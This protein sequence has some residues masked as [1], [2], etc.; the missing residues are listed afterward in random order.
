MG[1]LLRLQHHSPRFELPPSF[2]VE[3]SK[4]L[5]EWR[6]SL[7]WKVFKQY[8]ETSKNAFNPPQLVPRPVEPLHGAI[9]HL[10]T[11]YITCPA[12][13]R[14]YGSP[15]A[16]DGKYLCGIETLR[17]PCSIFSLGSH[18]QTTFEEEMLKLTPC[19][20]YTFDCYAGTKKLGPNH[21]YFQLCIGSVDD[22]NNSY[23]TYETAVMMTG[24]LT[25]SLLKMDIEGSEFDILPFW[26]RTYK[27]LPEQLAI[28]IHNAGLYLMTPH[29][30]NLNAE[31]SGHL[32]WA[33]IEEIN[34]G[35]LALTFLHLAE[36]GYGIVMQD[37]KG[38]C[39]EY[40][41]MRV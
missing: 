26:D 9:H 11:P 37:V 6:S 30:H 4:N 16:D 19:K 2:Y 12:S 29:L 39:A 17:A 8:S 18:G 28:E 41:L 5:S 36:L 25:P 20:V 7:V 3:G 15:G 31:A 1:C 24:G 34:L 32:I 21:E 14:F 22:K 33:G 40:V 38:N 35:Q 13:L 27:H 10:F 23:V